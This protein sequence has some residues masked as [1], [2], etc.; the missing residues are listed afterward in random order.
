[1]GRCIDRVCNYQV[2][3]WTHL[4]NVIPDLNYLNNLNNQIVE[5]ANL[6][7]YYWELLSK[8]NPNY[9][10]AL[11]MYAEYLSFIRNN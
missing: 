7:D 8:I 10:S 3:F 1:M 11:F 5:S 9:P 6:A 2:E 4:A